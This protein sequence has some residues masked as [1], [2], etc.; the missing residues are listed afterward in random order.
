[1]RVLAIALLILGCGPSYTD[2]LVLVPHTEYQ[3]LA[4]RS[5]SEVCGVYLGA[6]DA[7]APGCYVSLTHCGTS[8]ETCTS[9]ADERRLS[10]GE[11]VSLCGVPSRCECPTG[12]A[13]TIAH[14]PGTITLSAGAG[15]ASFGDGACLGTPRYDAAARSFAIC[16]ITVRECESACDERQVD[17]SVGARTEVCG[18]LVRCEP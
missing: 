11:Q 12:A 8:G 5:R 1:V 14:P 3:Q 9:L 2:S 7:S 13:P 18:R 16:S 10:C 4:A 6:W 15:G 17:I